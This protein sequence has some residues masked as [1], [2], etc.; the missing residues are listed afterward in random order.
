[1]SCER[2][3]SLQSPFCSDVTMLSSSPCPISCLQ[4]LCSEA[5]VLSGNLFPSMVFLF[6]AQEKCLWQTHG[7]SQKS[8]EHQSEKGTVVKQN[9]WKC[10]HLSQMHCN[11]SLLWLTLYNSGSW[12]KL[13]LTYFEAYPL[14]GHCRWLP[15]LLR[16]KDI[17]FQGQFSK[18]PWVI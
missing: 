12:N 6:T 1:M 9:Y 18:I 5:S 10:V 4:R 8:R 15:K 11:I 17:R 2:T 13:I 16:A 7:I 14:L 3:S